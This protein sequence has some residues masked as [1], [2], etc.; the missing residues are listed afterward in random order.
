MNDIFNFKSLL[1]NGSLERLLLN[2]DLDL[3][4][5][6]VGFGPDETRVNDSNFVQAPKLA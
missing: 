1:N 5:P 4:T 2:C 3:N 6:R